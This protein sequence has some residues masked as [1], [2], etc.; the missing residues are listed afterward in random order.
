MRLAHSISPYGISS[1]FAIQNLSPYK[2]IVRVVHSRTGFEIMDREVVILY[3]IWHPNVLSL[4][5]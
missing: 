2:F 5:F 4:P 3:N 1:L